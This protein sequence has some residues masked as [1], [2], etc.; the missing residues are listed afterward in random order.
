M[1]NM[2]IQKEQEY[3][4]NEHLR[5]I[6]KKQ[7]VHSH[8]PPEMN[9]LLKYFNAIINAKGVKHSCKEHLLSNETDHTISL[10][11]RHCVLERVVHRRD[12]YKSVKWVN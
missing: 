5:P 4:V 6:L 8:E 3:Q 2:R 10:N 1:R 7:S 12:S 9:R 11:F